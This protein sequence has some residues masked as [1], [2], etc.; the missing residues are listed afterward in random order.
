ME[1]D[2]FD[3]STILNKNTN[4]AIVTLVQ[5]YHVGELPIEINNTFEQIS[6]FV[7]KNPSP[8]LFYNCGEGATSS[9]LHMTFAENQIYPMDNLFKHNYNNT[10]VRKGKIIIS[11]LDEVKKN[12]IQFAGAISGFTQDITARELKDI[13]NIVLPDMPILLLSQKYIGA[14]TPEEKQNEENK[15]YVRV[16]KKQLVASLEEGVKPRN[17]IVYTTRDPIQ[18]QYL[19]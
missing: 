4:R 8:I 9:L 15:F 5:K 1:E 2:T 11:N 16:A 6:E 14:K 17:S 7:A 18:Q 10:L 19:Y 12:N 3:D 13:S